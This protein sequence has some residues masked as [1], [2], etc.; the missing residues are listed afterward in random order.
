MLVRAILQT[1]ISFAIQAAILFFAADDWTWQ[2]GWAWLG[3]VFALSVAITGW[4]YVND[5]ELLKARLSNP[6]KKGQRPADLMIAI[7]VFVLYFA[8]IA[9]LGLDARRFMWTSVPLPAQIVGAV[10]VGA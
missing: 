4:L 7:V 10:L 1:V 3:E 5:P 2:Q 6:L 8:W 9:L